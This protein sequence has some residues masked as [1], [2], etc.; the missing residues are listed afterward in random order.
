[1]TNQLFGKN[2]PWNGKTFGASNVGINRFVQTKK[3]DSNEKN[4]STSIRKTHNFAYTI[5]PSIF[6]G[7]SIQLKYSPYQGNLSLW[8]TMVDELRIIKVPKGKI[9]RSNQQNNGDN[10]DYILLGMGSM[11]WS[12]GMYNCQPFC[13]HKSTISQSTTSLSK[14]DSSKVSLASK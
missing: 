6:G 5:Q 13:L 2:E 11:A 14:A 8:K 10:T 12:G 3:E 1:M 9:E 7:S 4:S